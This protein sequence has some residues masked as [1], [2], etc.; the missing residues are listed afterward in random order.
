LYIPGGAGFL[1]STVPLST[2]SVLAFNV[3]WGKWYTPWHSQWNVN[4]PSGSPNLL[5]SMAM[6][7]T[8]ETQ[9]HHRFALFESPPL[10]GNLITHMGWFTY[11]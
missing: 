7:N 6:P 3:V 1:P 11:L 9:N 5:Q 8:S 2:G 10:M 4:L